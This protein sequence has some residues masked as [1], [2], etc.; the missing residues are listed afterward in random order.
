MLAY[1]V[2]VGCWWN[3][4]RGWTLQP[5]VCKL[6]CRATDSSR[7][8]VWQNGV[9]HGSAYE[10]ETCHWIH[11]CGKN[12][13]HWHSLTL[14]ER[15]RRPYSG[16]EHS[17]EVGGAFQQWRQW[18]VRQATVRTAL[19]SCGLTNWRRFDRIFR[20]NG[21]FTTR[22]LCPEMNIGFIAL[23]TT[24]AVVEYREVCERWIHRMLTLEHRDQRLQLCQILMDCP[25]APTVSSGFDSSWLSSVRTDGGWITWAIFSSQRHY[26]RSYEKVG[27][28]CWCRFL[29]MLAILDKGKPETECI[30]A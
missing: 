14:A 17:E 8:A 6:C 27:H 16:R 15:L 9:W 20:A 2:R 28:L 30:K 25:A 22:E 26:H 11:I 3:D 5:I 24:L 13:T 23:E 21:R 29:I 4:S 1:D 18:Y 19:H 10:A 12:C 7:G